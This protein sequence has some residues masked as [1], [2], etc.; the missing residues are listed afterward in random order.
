MHS[1]LRDVTVKSGEVT[2]L[3]VGG[4]GTLVTGQLALS[5]PSQEIDWK[6]SGHHYFNSQPNPPPYKTAE[7]YRAWEKLPET[8][9]ARKKARYYAVQLDERGA[10]RI[11]DVLPGNYALH[12]NLMQQPNA[13][14][15]YQTTLGA[16]TTN[17]V[18]SAR[19]DAAKT[20]TVDLGRLEIPLT[21]APQRNATLR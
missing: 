5:D 6:N 2:R 10:F 11:E 19:G 9:E 7:E 18:V 14:G 17:I 3:T 16:L 8:I 20:Q 21:R 15:Q 13:S 4:D 1:P 12:F